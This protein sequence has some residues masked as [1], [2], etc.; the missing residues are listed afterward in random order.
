MHPETLNQTTHI[1][2]TNLFSALK[3]FKKINFI[4]TCPNMDV[5]HKKIILEIK[6]FVRENKNSYYFESLGKNLYFNLLKYID[7]VIGNSS[8]GIIEVPSFNIP[9]INIGNRQKGRLQSRTIFNSDNKSENI[10]KLIKKIVNKNIK[11]KGN[12]NI[13]FKKFTEEKNYKNN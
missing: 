6:R 11:F 9:T 3:K 1:T 4:F 12:N 2:L 10:Y 5:D 7:G 13:Y 8:S